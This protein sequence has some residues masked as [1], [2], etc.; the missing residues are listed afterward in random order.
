MHKNKF[1]QKTFGVVPKGQINLNVFNIFNFVHYDSVITFQTNK[2][3][4]SYQ[5]YNDIMK[6]QLLHV[7]GLIGPSSGS[8]QFYKTAAVSP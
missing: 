1:L 4:R 5:D 8:T 2:C 6:H 7:S 3:T